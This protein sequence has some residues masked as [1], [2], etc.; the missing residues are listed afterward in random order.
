MN[1]SDRIKEKQQNKT[2]L[3][4]VAGPR[5][6]GKTG[7]LGTLPNKTLVIE[8]TDKESGSDGALAVAKVT[9]NSLD[10]VT[11]NDCEDALALA[12]EAFNLGYDNVAIDGISALTEVEADKPKIKKQLE[13][14]GNAVFAGWRLIGTAV[15]NLIQDLKQLSAEVN[16]PIILTLALKE[17]KDREGNVT[18]TDVET[19]GNMAESLIRGK[20]PFYVVARMAADKDGNPLYVLQTKDDGLYGARL[21]GVLS[22]HNPKGFRTEKSK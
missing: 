1:L 15:V 3:I 11:G 9:G 14:T 16:K 2:K 8:I 12:K 17:I 20:C 5:F 13:G 22:E 7:S 18:S 19:K 21:D 10:V 6:G 4:V